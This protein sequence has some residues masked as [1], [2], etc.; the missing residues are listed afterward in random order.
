MIAG[1]PIYACAI[2][3]VE[4]VKEMFIITAAYDVF[5]SEII[6]S[7][8]MLSLLTRNPE[9]FNRLQLYQITL[10]SHFDQSIKHANKLIHKQSNHLYCSP[11]QFNLAAILCKDKYTTPMTMSRQV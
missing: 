11:C 4:S 6:L 3:L 8:I 9:I 2:D 10:Q 7:F 5:N 1:L